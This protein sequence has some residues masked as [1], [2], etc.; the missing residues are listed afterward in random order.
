MDVADVEGDHDLANK[1]LADLKGRM[2]NWFGGE[3]PGYFVQD[4]KI[5][6]VVGY[7]DE[8]GSVKAMNDHHFHYGYWINAAAQIGLRD[9]QWASQNQ[10]G[11]MVNLLVS[12]IAN[13]T[14]GANNFPFIRNF[15]PYEG[16]SWASGDANFP[17]G[18][19][20]ES[21]SEAVNAWAGL[22]LWGEVT[23]NQAVRDLGVWLYTTETESISDYWFDQRK[24]V[25][26]PSYGKPVAAMVFGARYAYSTWWTQ[27]PRQI[28][29]I[30]LLPIT[31]ASVY[32][33]RDPAYIEEYFKN[34]PAEKK[35]YGARGM[36]DGTP[37]DIW[38][39]VLVSFEA[40]GNPEAALKNWKPKGSTESGE[41]RS[42][43]L[44]WML[45]LK[46]MGIPDFS[47]TANTPLYGVFH[48]AGKKTYLAYN[49][50]AK[51]IDV[52]FSDGKKLRVEPY[53]LSRE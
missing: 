3:G 40:L 51:A 32:L 16:H 13:T 23:G 47:V 5:G 43:T 49:A 36:D 29:G 17:D 35:A 20:Q 39:D 46:E 52:Q 7:P 10:W 44:Y 6:T 26:P 42:H 21:S 30:N 9:P 27:E 22:I 1:L 41:T 48:N 31:P 38:Q 4:K 50:S 24:I 18:N 15:D 11:G 19:N 12:D 37:D 2:Q 53:K 34:L 14:R 8:F 25:F 28:Q 33:G 45:S